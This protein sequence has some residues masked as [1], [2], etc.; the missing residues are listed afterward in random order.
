[1]P[2]EAAADGGRACAGGGSR[3]ASPSAVAGA[4][5]VLVALADA[6]AAS[7]VCTGS[8]LLSAG[9]PIIAA[10]SIGASLSAAATAA[11]VTAAGAETGTA[12][13]PAA[14]PVS[15]PLSFPSALSPSPV[16]A[17]AVALAGAE[18]VAPITGA[19]CVAV[20]TSP[21]FTARACWVC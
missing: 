4:V 9:G 2:M 17:P 15:S 13:V 5:S 18:P 16:S 10:T 20:G 3:G 11:G 21:V 12:A 19:T 1:M 7:T 8:P 14:P 6:D